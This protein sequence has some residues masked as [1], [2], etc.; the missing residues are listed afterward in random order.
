[1]RYI[2]IKNHNVV[3][4]ENTDSLKVTCPRCYVV[5][6]DTRKNLNIEIDEYEGVFYCSYNCE[7]CMLAGEIDNVHEHPDKNKTISTKPYKCKL[8]PIDEVRLLFE[9]MHQPRGHKKEKII[10]Y[11]NGF[12]T[13]NPFYLCELRKT[14]QKKINGKVK[15]TFKSE[16]LRKRLNDLGIT[17]D[18]IDESKIKRFSNNK[19]NVVFPYFNGNT[20]IN[21]R[22]CNILDK[23]ERWKKRQI[24]GAFVNLFN[25]EMVT[26]GKPM[27]ICK[28]E[29]EVL[30]LKSLGAVNVASVIP[31]TNKEEDIENY[32][33]CII[34]CKD[35]IV[36]AKEIYLLSTIEKCK[37]VIKSLS[38]NI[39]VKIID[40][41]KFP[42]IID[43]FN[44]KGSD[45]VAR[46]INES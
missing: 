31:N 41:G 46:R 14:Y 18:V 36:L 40:M 17:D 1:M 44:E 11:V 30:L 43:M 24:K 33:N 32:T 45:Y 42:D 25:I 15:K 38:Q 13:I 4:P 26:I 19:A 5:F 9:E 28:D 12:R 23:K 16:K 37:D 21:I 35:K 7:R 27:L 2:T 34:N 39:D 20:I 10:I 3:I 22:N 29:M 6:M 8:S